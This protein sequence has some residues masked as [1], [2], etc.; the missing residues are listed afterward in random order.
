MKLLTMCTLVFCL[1]MML[2]FFPDAFRIIE[3]G[4]R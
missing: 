3:M 2:V 1:A 4:V